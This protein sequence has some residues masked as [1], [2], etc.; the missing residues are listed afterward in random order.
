MM[1][2]IR[3]QRRQQVRAIRQ[4]RNQSGIEQFH[5][6]GL[7]AGGSIRAVRQCEICHGEMGVMTMGAFEA[8]GRMC[9]LCAER[10]TAEGRIAE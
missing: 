4:R 1:S 7:V 6:L 10:L 3:K 8:A 5:R 9:D 2:E